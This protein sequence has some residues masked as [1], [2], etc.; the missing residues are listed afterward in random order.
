MIQFLSGKG[1]SDLKKARL[2]ND[3]RYQDINEVTLGC[4][5]YMQTAK[6]YFFFAG[7]ARGQ[8]ESE[9]A[10]AGVTSFG[11]SRFVTADDNILDRVL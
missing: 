9:A 6:G 5:E 10:D 7:S 1:T 11:H 4:F 2:T 8:Y 3:V